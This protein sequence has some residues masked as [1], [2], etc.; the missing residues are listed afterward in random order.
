M[1]SSNGQVD[2]E[3]AEPADGTRGADTRARILAAAAELI[4][5]R[6]WSAVTT[7][8]IAQRADVPHGAVSYHFAGKDELLRRAAVA[9]T[10]A[11]LGDPIAMTRAATS[12]TEVITI[13]RAYLAGD[14]PAGPQM[15]L[16]LETA[17]QATRDPQLRDP[18][19]EVLAQYR[20][21]MAKLIESDQQAGT[22]RSDADPEALAAAIAALFDGLA[23]HANLD[24]SL[25]TGAVTMLLDALIRA[26]S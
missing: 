7:R 8:E 1:A 15:A 24:A 19:A 4:G 5:E 14:E 9:G 17:R 12:L 13:M 22:V 6:G 16:V 20:D 23:V 2:R 11:A 21:V 26:P 10:T 18:I 3:R 25:D